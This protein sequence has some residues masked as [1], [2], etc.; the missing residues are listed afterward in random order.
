LGEHYSSSFI[1]RPTAET[2]AELVKEVNRLCENAKVSIRSARHIAQKQIKS[3]E[4]R[5]VV[6][7]DE[8]NREM[9]EVRKGPRY[10]DA[11]KT[12]DP[13]LFSLFYRWKKRQRSTL[14]K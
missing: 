12:Y 1:Y 7:K 4:K 8:A 5:K 11:A 6:S 13:S 2:R 10:G 9:K 3:D 14:Q